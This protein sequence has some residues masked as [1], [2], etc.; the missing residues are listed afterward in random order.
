MKTNHLF[1]ASL[2]SVLLMTTVAAR[3]IAADADEQAVV[4]AEHQWLESQK[5]NNTELLA[6]LLADKV[7]ETNS[8]GKTFAGK[9]AVIAD[10]KSD[11]WSSAEYQD[12]K[13]T[14]FDKTAI[15]SGI[16][17]GQA[18]DAAGKATQYRERFTDTWVKMANGKWL[19]VAS[20]TSPLKG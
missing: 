8:R 11:S 16:F 5:T 9:A 17:S 10:A 14:V 19:C 20:H 15:A 7:L 6:P 18:K 3:A 2:A 13:V 1:L 4:A 12:L